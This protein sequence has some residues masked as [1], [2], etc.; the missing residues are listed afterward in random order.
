VASIS[1]NTKDGA[2]VL[3]PGKVLGIG[4]IDH[5]V[6]VGAYSFS[7]QAREKI[8]S[9]GGTCLDISEF[10]KSSPTAKDMVLLG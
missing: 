3:V 4:K 6:T 1:R 2:R 9:I 7:K 8:S 5:K 10:M